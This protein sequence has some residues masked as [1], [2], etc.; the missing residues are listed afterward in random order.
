MKIRFGYVAIALQLQDGSPNKTLTYKRFSELP[1]AEY[2]LH[3]LHSITKENLEIT[4]RILL[5]NVAHDIQLYR[6]TS[7]LVPLIT[8]EEVVD[9]DYIEP[10]KALY[11]TIGDYIKEHRLR[12]S[13]HPDHFTVLNTPNK[14]VLETA[15]K[16]LDYH[17]RIFEAMGLSAKEAKLVIHVGGTY[18]SKKKAIERFI[19]QFKQIDPRFQ[20]RIMLENDDKSFTAKE[21]LGICQTLKIPMVLDIHH[22]FCNHQGEKIEDLLE[23]IFNTW[24]NEAHPPKIHASSPKCEKQIRAH[25]DY[26]DA[27]FLMDFVRIAKVLNRD[28]DVMVEAKQKDL[29]LLRLMKELKNVKQIKILDGASIEV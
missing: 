20:E 7:K 29:A 9:W 16:D 21:V 12:V 1:D 25:A 19:E 22:H 24:D 11:S 26:V 2:K 28:F 27:N 5:Y 4:R 23:D 8:H 18:G 10:F 14:A 17:V 3:K 6:F 15:L 13:A